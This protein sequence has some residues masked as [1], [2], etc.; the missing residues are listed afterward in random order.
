MIRKLLLSIGLL[1]T[2]SCSAQLADGA[3]AP[4]FTV[5]D[6]SGGV[7]N[8]HQQLG[9]GKAVILDF[10]TTW[11]GPC[12]DYHKSGA[13]EE[14]WMNYGPQGTDEAKVFFIES[15]EYTDLEDLQGIGDMTEGDWLEGTEYPMIDDFVLPLEYQVNYYPTLYLVCPDTTYTFYFYTIKLHSFFSVLIS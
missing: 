2:I 7:W 11:C 6:L 14:F 8:L 5:T 10:S 9:Q 4:D 13:L 1:A 15:D 3:M 12:W